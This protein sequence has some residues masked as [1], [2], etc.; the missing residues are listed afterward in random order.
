MDSLGCFLILV[1]TSFGAYF[2]ARRLGPLRLAE[3]RPAALDVVDCIGVSV[4]FLVCN[5]ALGAG[6]LLGF[7]ALTGRFVS[8]YV[9]N[10]VTM[11]ILSSV[12]ALVF[13]RWWERS[14]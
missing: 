13:I 2:A 9:L 7:R 1:P 4:L 11:P 14:R 12:Q 8:V 3:L 5:L 10:D 6:L